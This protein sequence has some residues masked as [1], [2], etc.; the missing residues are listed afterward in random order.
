M[1]VHSYRLYLRDLNA[2]EESISAMRAFTFLLLPQ[3]AG[4]SSKLTV[5]D[6]SD[7]SRHVVG[8]ERLLMLRASKILDWFGDR[9]SPRKPTV[10]SFLIFAPTVDRDSEVRKRKKLLY[11]WRCNQT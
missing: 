9:P 1:Q 11:R 2:I 4:G 10:K 8:C 7:T 6:T 5:S 3:G